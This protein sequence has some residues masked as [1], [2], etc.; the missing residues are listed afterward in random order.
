MEIIY[1]NYIGDDYGSEKINTMFLTERVFFSLMPINAQNKKTICLSTSNPI[2]LDAINAKNP[3]VVNGKNIYMD[4]MYADTPDKIIN[5][6][7]MYGSIVN[8]RTFS[9]SIFPNRNLNPLKNV[10][11]DYSAALNDYFD[12]DDI[13]F[14]SHHDYIPMEIFLYYRDD[15]KNLIL[16]SDN[17]KKYSRASRK[18]KIKPKIPQ[19]LLKGILGLINNQ[20]YN[21]MYYLEYDNALDTK[22]EVLLHN[23]LYPFAWLR[24]YIN[25]NKCK[26]SPSKLDIIDYWKEIIDDASSYYIQNYIT[27]DSDNV[28]QLFQRLSQYI[29][30]YYSPKLFTG[31]YMGFADSFC[32]NEHK[33]IEEL[34][35]L[36]FND[37][38]AYHLQEMQLTHNSFEER[39][40]EFVYPTLAD[41]IFFY[42]YCDQTNSDFIQC[43]NPKC[44]KLFI[45][46]TTN[47][48]NIYCGKRCS[49][50]MTSKRHR[51]K[52]KN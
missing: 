28:L 23:Y 33:K 12:S 48:K 21:S 7:N 46:S 49:S 2:Y 41:A 17:I 35:R 24:S 43:A 44:R 37:F 20:Y 50:S 19:A 39:K 25:F 10:V 16:L 30:E 3:D 1:N 14:N 40:V 5:F 47:K 27:D 8:Y 42:F 32:K 26:P 11:Q 29:S 4:L 6:C 31:N 34:A 51:S 45:R 52:P 22:D 13:N 38:L 36:V 9:P 18:G 15:M